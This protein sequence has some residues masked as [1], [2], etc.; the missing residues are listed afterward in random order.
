MIFYS[1]KSDIIELMNEVKALRSDIHKLRAIVTDNY[2]DSAIYGVSPGVKA[3]KEVKAE[4]A[5]ENKS[6]HDLFLYSGNAIAIDMVYNR[7]MNALHA[8]GIKLVRDLIESNE[9]YIAKLP[10]VG[11]KCMNLLAELMMKHNL[12]F[13]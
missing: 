9:Q 10:N 12:K 7:L 6:L 5:L 3:I 2:R 13:I 8:D 11:Q 4:I 1:P